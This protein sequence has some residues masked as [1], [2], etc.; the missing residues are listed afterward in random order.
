AK[1]V[2]FFAFTVGWYFVLFLRPLL[3]STV[4]TN[5]LSVVAA[6][7]VIAAFLRV[8]F[9][10]R[11]FRLMRWRCGSSCQELWYVCGTETETA[12]G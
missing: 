12:K 10:H 8:E 2:G 1:Q 9:K 7:A 4:A 3:S 5:L 6:A 11:D